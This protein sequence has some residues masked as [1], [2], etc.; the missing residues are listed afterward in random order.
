MGD[1]GPDRRHA[2]PAPDVIT[3]MGCAPTV[4]WQITPN[5]LGHSNCGLQSLKMPAQAQSY[6]VTVSLK[7][8]ALS[9]L[10]VTDSKALAVPWLI[11]AR[12]MGTASP[13]ENLMTIK[14]GNLTATP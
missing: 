7:P 13:S 8:L 14:V 6:L 11:G 5:H 2:F 3:M 4:E 9:M 10:I 12:E 1:A